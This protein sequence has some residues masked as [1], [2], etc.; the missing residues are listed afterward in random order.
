MPDGP[1]QWETC[2]CCRRPRKEVHFSE[3]IGARACE[4]C[5]CRAAPASRAAL[6]YRPPRTSLRRRTPSAYERLHSRVWA[7]LARAGEVFLLDVGHLAAYCPVC[8]YGCV[9]VRFVDADP[10]QVDIECDAGCTPEQ[11][12]GA[13]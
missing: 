6:R 11:L 8:H 13:L 7:A 9:V 5:H 10:P 12:R 1:G 4:S 2:Q 3:A